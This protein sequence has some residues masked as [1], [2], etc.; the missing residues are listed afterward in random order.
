M[1]V[2]SLTHMANYSSVWTEPSLMF[3]LLA[4][5]DTCKHSP[6][7]GTVWLAFGLTFRGN[8]GFPYITDTGSSRAKGTG[9]SQHV[10]L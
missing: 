10:P 6:M 4:A 9:S 8:F 2:I 1:V 5:T 3:P 7:A